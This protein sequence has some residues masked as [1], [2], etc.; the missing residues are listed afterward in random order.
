MRNREAP[1]RFGPYQLIR[2]LASCALAERWLALH[3]DD[4]SSHVIYRFGPYR[5]KNERRRFVQA[6]ESVARLRHP[7]L[8][9][10]EQYSLDH[11]EWGWIVTPY[12]G[13]SEN[14]V[15]LGQ[16]LESKGGTMGAVEMDRCVRQLL[17]AYSYAHQ[18]R[19]YHGPVTMH[20]V[21]V[22]TR[23]SLWIELFGMRRYLEGLADGDAELVRDAIRSVIEIAYTLLTGLPADEPRISAS[24]LVRRLGKAWD[25]WFETGLDPH[26]G[27]ASADAALAALPTSEREDEPTPVVRTVLGRIRSSMGA[28]SG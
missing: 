6:A 17:E 1:E 25:V 14:L 16:V 18:K 11:S 9:P 3:E 12:T 24:R 8:M 27:F 28:K 21:L 22:D 2:P 5:D 23:G 15:H 4:E 10:I 19:R 20:D 7:H 26:A 13:N